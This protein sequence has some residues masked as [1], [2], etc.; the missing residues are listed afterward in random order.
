MARRRLLG[1]EQCAALFALWR[2]QEFS[3]WMTDTMHDAGDPALHGPVRQAMAR[4]CLD[5]LFSSPTAARQHSE[6]LRMTSP[7]PE[8]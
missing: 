1:D 4:A 5:A 6:Y 8:A 7:V 2:Y 3:A